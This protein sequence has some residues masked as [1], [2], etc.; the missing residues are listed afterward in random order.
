MSILKDPPF[1]TQIQ[2]GS[3]IE[4]NFKPF[5]AGSSSR[6]NNGYRRLA[7][8]RTFIGK[9][10]GD[11]NSIVSATGEL[12]NDRINIPSPSDVTSGQKIPRSKTKMQLTIF[13]NS[14]RASKVVID[15]AGKLHRVEPDYLTDILIDDQAEEE[16]DEEENAYQMDILKRTFDN[17]KIKDFPTEIEINIAFGYDKSIKEYFEEYYSPS[18][19]N[20]ELKNWMEDIHTHIQ[21]YYKLRTLKTKVH[22]K[23]NLNYAKLRTKILEKG[24]LLCAINNINAFFYFFCIAGCNGAKL[25]QWIFIII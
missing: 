11:N 19:A 2:N 8:P 18:S 25:L 22:L 24:Y 4:M 6:S 21:A 1:T 12:S 7:L 15:Q 5:K 9:I 20:V 14:T 13:N 17:L 23:V 3:I 10:K 16:D